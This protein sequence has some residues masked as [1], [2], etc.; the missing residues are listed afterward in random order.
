[1][2]RSEVIKELQ[3]GTLVLHYNDTKESLKVIQELIKEAFPNSTNSPA[4]MY[5]YYGRNIGDSKDWNSFSTIS[6]SRKFVRTSDIV[7]DEREILG[8]KSPINLFGGDIK[9]GTTFIKNGEDYV[10]YYAKDGSESQSVPKEVV[11]TWEAVYEEEKFIVRAIGD[12]KLNVHVT[13]KT[14]I[15]DGVNIDVDQLKNLY[16]LAVIVHP[17]SQSHKAV[18]SKMQVGCTEFTVAELEYIIDTY[19]SLQ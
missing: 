17:I 16:S 10:W 14:I 9:A 19:D 18:F 2:K 11:E 6:P 4:G 8:Y 13:K 15:A 5:R 12:K 7:T 3:D 1:M